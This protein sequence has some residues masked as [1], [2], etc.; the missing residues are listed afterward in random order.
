LSK[1]YPLS[2]LIFFPSHFSLP[3]SSHLIHTFPFLCL[4]RYP[5]FLNPFFHHL[6]SVP[7]PK[8][9]FPLFLGA[10]T[11]RMLFS[12]LPYFSFFTFSSSCVSSFPNYFCLYFTMLFNIPELFSPFICFILKLYYF[13]MPVLY[14]HED[15][16]Y[17]FTY[18][19][20]AN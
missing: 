13:N 7:S 5:V 4:F 9:I 10:S 8:S 18:Y 14:L 1:A 16:V 15:C 17:L 3:I 12:L 19:T 6:R 2:S 20:G 11:S